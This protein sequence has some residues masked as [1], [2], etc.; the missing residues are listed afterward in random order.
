MAT[1]RKLKSGKWQV[2]I[3]KKNYPK[4]IRS[5]ISKSLATKWSKMIETQMEKRVF[6]DMSGA[7]GTTL[8]QLLLKYRDEIV[9]TLKSETTLTYKINYLLKFKVC[10]YNLLEL[11]SAHINTFKREISVGRANKTINAYI[12]MLKLVWNLARSQWGITLPPQNPFILVSM[13]PVNNFRDIT[14]T[15]EQ[16]LRLV[17]EAD[18]ILIKDT[19][20]KVVGKAN[21]LPDMI[22]FA[23]AT[24]CRYSEIVNLE[25][26]NVDFNRCLA[27]LMDTKNGEDRTIPLSDEAIRILKKQPFGDRFFNIPSRDMFKNYFIRA[28]KKADLPDLRFHDLRSHAIRKMLLSGMQLVEVAKISGHKTLAVLH[29]RY[30]RLQPEDLIQKINNVVLMK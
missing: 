28:R 19:A 27:T 23:S 6:E 15:D 21:W 20:Q 3:R 10:Y 26:K 22:V 16:F 1:L 8:K 4:V 18:K 14:L 13:L 2:V 30:S 5:F 29:R 9:P 11:N 12:N 24:A 7:E 25:R 17:D